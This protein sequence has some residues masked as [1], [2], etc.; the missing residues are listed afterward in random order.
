MFITKS[1]LVNVKILRDKIPLS[2]YYSVKYHDY[3]QVK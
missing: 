3:K 2:T 1:T